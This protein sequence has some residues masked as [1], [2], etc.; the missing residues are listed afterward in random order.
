MDILVLFRKQISLPSVCAIFLEAYFCI[1]LHIP[2][3]R[4]PEVNDL[5]LLSGLNRTPI[6]S[7]LST[8]IF[9]FSTLRRTKHHPSPVIPLWYLFFPNEGPKLYNTLDEWAKGGFI[10]WYKESY[11]INLIFLNPH[12]IF[13][14]LLSCPHMTMLNRT[15]TSSVFYHWTSFTVRADHLFPI[16]ASCCFKLAIYPCKELSHGC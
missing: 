16:S 3:H 5:S 13:S 1:H 4:A 8:S 12:H 9:R 11:I 14:L 7:T 2:W 6:G 15:G 10:W